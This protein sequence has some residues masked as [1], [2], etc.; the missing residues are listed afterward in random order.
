MIRTVK[1]KCSIVNRF[2][3][4]GA[5]EIEA[6]LAFVRRY[7]NKMTEIQR[8]FRTKFGE[9]RAAAFPAF[10]AAEAAF[11]AAEAELDAAETA[12]KT[13][14]AKARKGVKAPPE[15][16]AARAKKKEAAA[17][18]KV[19]R[20]RIDPA[21]LKAATAHL[22]GEEQAAIKAATAE[23]GLTSP[24]AHEARQDLQ[25]AKRTAG[26]EGPRFRAH[27]GGGTIAIQVPAIDGSERILLDALK[28]ADLHPSAAPLLREG[29]HIKLIMGKPRF[30]TEGKAG[31]LLEGL[32]AWRTTP[33]GA[34]HCGHSEEARAAALSQLAPL[35]TWGDLVRGRITGASLRF[36][37]RDEWRAAWPKGRAEGRTE[38]RA[39]EFRHPEA[40]K[41]PQPDSQRSKVYAYG[42]LTIRV[43]REGAEALLPVWQTQDRLPPLEAQVKQVELHARRLG[44]GKDGRPRLLYSVL[45]SIDDPTPRPARR[46]GVVAVNVGWRPRPDGSVRA[47]YFVG[48]DGD[49][50]EIAVPATILRALERADSLRA[51]RDQRFD[52]AKALLGRYLATR[53]ESPAWLTEGTK[54]LAQW[55]DGRRLERL[56]VQWRQDRLPGDEEVFEALAGTGTGAGRPRG[57]PGDE[58]WLPKHLHLLS[59]EQDKR[60]KALAQRKD[61]FRRWGKRLAERYGTLLLEDF[62]LAAV[63]RRPK[64]EE[65]TAKEK[66]PLVKLMNAAAPGELRECQIIAQEMRGGAVVKRSVPFATQDCALCGSKERWSPAESILHTCSNCR[67]QVDQDWQNCQNRLVEYQPSVQG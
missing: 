35:R 55:R 62:D 25:R 33:E 38:G 54:G 58:A 19:E 52:L 2:P 6:T 8:A 28:A 7:K 4:K 32:R 16:A 50:G 60:R 46:R 18:L 48:S 43:N 10:A 51:I 20:E 17:A 61:L 24:T 56:L 59:W 44:I 45:V 3:P 23:A 22:A 39:E 27:D 37:D 57:M 29:G 31:D 40:H 15:V 12:A 9:L 47:G 67:A 53:A 36:C 26:P 42:L 41:E 5:A 64:V 1:L 66:T 34:I 63:R 14:R 21:A 49:H 30:V 65:G 13:A 11:E